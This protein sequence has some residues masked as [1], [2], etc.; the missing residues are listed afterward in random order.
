MTSISGDNGVGAHTSVKQAQRGAARAAS[1]EVKAPS[2]AATEESGDSVEISQE[3]RE[4]LEKSASSE[5]WR[6]WSMMEYETPLVGGSEEEKKFRELMKSVK[7]QKSDIMSQ[8]KDI[9][10][11]HGIS[12]ADYG[13]VKIEV[14]DSGKISVGGVRDAKTAKAIENALNA[15]K[16]LGKKVL[17]FQRDEKEL[18]KQIKEYSGCTLFELTMTQRGDVNARIRECV[19]GATKDDS[20]DDEFYWNLGFLGEN[21]N[22]VVGV[23]D[24]FDLGFQGA[25]DFS[26]ETNTLAEPERNI[27]NELEAMYRKV[28]EDFD[29]HN[30]DVAARMEA[31]G[32]E[33][34]DEMKAMYFL[35]AAGV[36]ITVDNLGAMTVEGLFSDNG[37]NHKTGEDMVRKRVTEMLNKTE[38]NSYHI[39]IFTSASA[40]LIRR[41]ADDS[42]L[43]QTAWDARVVA[44]INGG[45]VGGI[46]VSP[47]S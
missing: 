45:A 10:A 29:R 5:A 20:P 34:T 35:D 9:F 33:M 1:A 31:A 25:I 16:T 26:G 6:P 18:S 22:H 42:G 30:A 8:V 36:T 28:Q 3:A 23:Q 12:R 11:R 38:D 21:L 44:E 46:R 32:I 47:R 7:S 17:Q 14:D 40:T 13:K 39:N 24:V 2:G 43:E 41:M 4:L 37:D 15:D 19:E 27:E